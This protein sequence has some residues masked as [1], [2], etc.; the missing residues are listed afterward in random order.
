MILLQDVRYTTFLL[1]ML[2]IIYKKSRINT[3]LKRPH[4]H[5][6]DLEHSDLVVPNQSQN[7]APLFQKSGSL[8]PIHSGVDQCKQT[9][10]RTHFKAPLSKAG[11]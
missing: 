10:S 1:G 5:S 7:Q 4:K 9:N 6:P 8:V 11:Q 3:C 2:H